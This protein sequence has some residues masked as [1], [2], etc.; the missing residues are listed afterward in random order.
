M[1]M[2]IIDCIDAQISALLCL[3]LWVGRR[4]HTQGGGETAVG[5]AAVMIKSMLKGCVFDGFAQ[6]CVQ[7]I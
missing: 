5:V 3:L 4:F 6:N 7:L 1:V 2:I